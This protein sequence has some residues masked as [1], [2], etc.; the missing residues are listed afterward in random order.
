MNKHIYFVLFSL[1]VLCVAEAGTR[2]VYRFI[3]SNSEYS[4]LFEKFNEDY[5]LTEEEV[6]LLDQA[7]RR[8]SESNAYRL[9]SSFFIQS[10]LKSISFLVNLFFIIYLLF[11]REFKFSFGL[12]M[13]NLFYWLVV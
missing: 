1:F 9:S 8:E 13:F 6:E 4:V 2:Y 5:M 7:L 12:F 3:S 11:L 10:I